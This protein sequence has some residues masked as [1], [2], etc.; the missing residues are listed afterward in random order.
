M[1]SQKLLSLVNT[2]KPEHDKFIICVHKLQ[3]N[4][5]PIVDR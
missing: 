5:P 2:A 1:V 4:Y 3:L